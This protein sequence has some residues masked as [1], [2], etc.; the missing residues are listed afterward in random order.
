MTSIDTMTPRSADLRA[1][2]RSRAS[3]RSVVRRQCPPALLPLRDD[4]RTR[5]AWGLVY[6]LR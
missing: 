1:A 2:E 4:V 3:R 6:K 5:L